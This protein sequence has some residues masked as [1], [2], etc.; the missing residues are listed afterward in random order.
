[1]IN[2]KEEKS[3]SLANNRLFFYIFLF[4]KNIFSLTVLIILF[5]SISQLINYFFFKT[6][7]FS[8]K[9][10]ENLLDESGDKNK[11]EDNSFYNDN[12]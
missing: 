1:M 8:N 6:N 5:I 9:F 7:S 4:I 10:E 11:K 12:E 2:L 3:S